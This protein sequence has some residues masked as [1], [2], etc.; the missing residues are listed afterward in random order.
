ML[1]LLA[2]NGVLGADGQAESDW[3]LRPSHDS[4][5]VLV[6]ATYNRAEFVNRIPW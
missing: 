1:I 2:L 3:C 4:F 5:S 6:S